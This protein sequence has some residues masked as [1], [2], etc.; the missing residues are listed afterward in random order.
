MP[1]SLLVPVDVEVFLIG[2]DGDGGYAHRQDTLQ[3]HNLLDA[4]LNQHCP[5][6]LET[7][8]E[9]GVCFQINYQVM[10]SDFIGDEVGSCTL[11]TWGKMGSWDSWALN[12]LKQ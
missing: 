11:S 10:G 7:Q 5:H 3:L 12:D 4:G 2:F 6:S 9:L 1:Q 8:E